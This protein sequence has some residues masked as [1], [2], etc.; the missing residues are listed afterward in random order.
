MKDA[1]ISTMCLPDLICC[2]SPGVLRGRPGAEAGANTSGLDGR[3]VN[4]R[5]HLRRHDRQNRLRFAWRCARRSC[6]VTLKTCAFVDVALLPPPGSFF[7]GVPMSLLIAIV[8][9]SRP[10]AG[11]ISVHQTA[12]LGVLL[13]AMRR[14]SACCSVLFRVM[15]VANP[16]EHVMLPLLRSGFG[17]TADIRG[18]PGNVGGWGKA[19]LHC[20]TWSGP[21]MTDCVAKV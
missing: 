6:F 3:G 9:S 2:P 4:P 16:T 1:T 18:T 15:V 12:F 8:L 13:M 17:P 14:S 11:T 10:F 20:C 19:E 21:F 7:L 5:R